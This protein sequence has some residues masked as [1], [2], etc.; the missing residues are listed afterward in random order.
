MWFNIGLFSTT[1]NRESALP[2]GRNEQFIVDHEGVQWH[3]D[4]GALAFVLNVPTL[5]FGYTGYAVATSVAVSVM[6]ITSSSLGWSGT[7]SSSSR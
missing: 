2:P 3:Q 5:W 6:R 1:L 4:S 7:L